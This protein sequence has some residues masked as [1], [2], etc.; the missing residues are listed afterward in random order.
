MSFSLTDYLKN[1]CSQTYDINDL[2][3]IAEN[4]ASVSKNRYNQ[5]T[6]LKL[7]CRYANVDSKKIYF[8][9]NN[10]YDEKTF[11]IIQRDYDKSPTK[12][13][14]S[15]M[16]NFEKKQE[17]KPEL[18]FE[19]KQPK[20]DVVPEKSVKSGFGNLSSFEKKPT[21]SGFGNLSSYEKKQPVQE[22]EKVPEKPTKSGFGNLSSF[23]KTQPKKEIPN[24][25]TNLNKLPPFGTDNFND[26]NIKDDIWEDEETKRSKIYRYLASKYYPAQRSEEWFK[27]R[28]TMITAS[29]G[30]TIV[31]MNPYET[32]YSFIS[33]KV[34]G[35]PFETS[36]SCYHG[37]KLEQVATMIY[38]YR[39]NV[40]VMEFGLCQ[41]PK[42]NFLGASPDGIV[43]EYK[44]KTKSGKTWEELE[45]ELKLIKKQEDKFKFLTAN[46]YKTKYVGRMLEIKCPSGRQIIM[47]KEAPEVYGVHGEKITVLYKDVKKGICPAYYWVQVQ[48]QLQCCEL[49]ECDFWQMSITEYKNRQDFEK[50]TNK[51][52]QWLSIE[53]KMEKGALI[54]LMP[55]N[56]LSNNMLSYEEKIY[57]FAG[58]I[59]QPRINM[60]NKEID[61]WI[62]ETLNKL[63]KT[64][65]DYVL[66]TILYWRVE[67]SRNITI[68]RDDKW[69]NDNL[70]TFKE[71][72]ELVLFFRNEKELATLFKKYLLT[73]PLDNFKHIK[74]PQKDTIMNT[75]KELYKKNKTR[76]KEIEKLTQKI[77]ITENTHN[78]ID[79]IAFIENEL[80]NKKDDVNIIELIKRL[81]YDLS[82]KN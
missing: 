34:H 14:L 16:P 56:Q 30:G 68:K 60:T 31:G 36:Q 48:L 9:T 76:T 78:I 71:S 54:Q 64:H 41:H 70:Q 77:N 37:K 21:K 63:D 8:D 24:P 17:I 59:Y 79:D 75:L 82:N 52:T 28:D 66:D 81:K 23:E 12:P 42:Y 6:A 7:I 1:N 55:K 80:K 29:D 33:K 43:S 25:Q 61:E 22:L 20:Q 46:C 50:D 3:T 72:W 58:F 53:T 19:K 10:R 15:D 73:F 27:M 67:N 11:D 38:E 62:F 4:I 47:D 51:Q 32:N 2:H 40:K 39:M 44:L 35:K 26:E 5:D 49:D 65:P 69:F 74:E 45:E 13:V 18:S 57:N